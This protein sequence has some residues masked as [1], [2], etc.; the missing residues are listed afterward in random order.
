ML[1]EVAALRARVA[2]LDETVRR[3]HIVNNSLK[4][5]VKRS[6]RNAGDAFSIFE[7]NIRLQEEV[8][9]QVADLKT[10]KV[11]AEQA[12]QAKSE[13]LAT[14]SHEIRTPMNGVIGMTTLLMD[15]ALSAEQR[16]YVDSI[17][18]SG[19]SLLEIINDI[20]DFSKFES[21]HLQ[22]EEAPFTLLPSVE[23]TLELVAG[24]ALGKGVDLQY[25]VDPA[26]P[27]TVIGDITRLRQILWNLVS[28]A[29]KFTEVGEVRLE[30]SL[31]ERRQDVIWLQ[32]KVVDTGIGMPSDRIDR[33]FKPFSQM[34][35]STTRRYGGTGLGLAICKKLTQFMDGD[36]WVESQPG[37]GSTFYFKVRLRAADEP[38]PLAPRQL[39]VLLLE[40]RENR[41]RVMQK[42]L[43]D[44]GLS[45]RVCESYEQASGMLEGVDLGL[46][47]VVSASDH[48]RAQE[49]AQALMPRPTIALMGEVACRSRGRCSAC[50]ADCLPHI[51]RQSVL[52]QSIDRVAC[53]AATPEAAPVVDKTLTVDP[54]LA[55][56]Y[57]LHILVAEDN[58]VNQKLAVRL[59]SRFGYLADVA[60]NGLEV[61]EALQRKSYDLI[62]MD[63]MMPEMDG[64]E[65]T[66]KIIQ[67]CPNI[68]TPIIIAMTA[69]AMKGDRELC[70]EAGMN[71]YISKP[72]SPAALN[73]TITRWG[74][75][76][77]GELTPNP[78]FM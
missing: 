45:V 39:R 9:R 64:L 74:E 22:L 5:R 7:S 32:G 68:K 17:R 19:E 76:A 30:L 47:S 51:P 8:D 1:D 44:W 28:N 52:F 11:A 69:N 75:R 2:E 53:Q 4:E 48:C 54:E 31:A 24:R 65:T 15:T 29:I 25:L 72:I 61:L 71:D 3:L 42:R 26:L 14:M 6:I 50:F 70:L 66:R 63:V 21:G 73:S 35:S 34:D 20:L 23:E 40:G 78:L 43:E 41:R 37:S 62:F 58:G 49:L 55:Q 57:P 27:T 56:R 10:A 33:L 38:P 16:E 77:R 67:F 18:V 36:I 59:L 13:F 60:A 12:A 46:L